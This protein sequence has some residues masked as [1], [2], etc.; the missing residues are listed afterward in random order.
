MFHRSYHFVQE[1][2]FTRYLFVILYMPR[3]RDDVHIVSTEAAQKGIG[4]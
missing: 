4:I 2:Y 3:S 1:L